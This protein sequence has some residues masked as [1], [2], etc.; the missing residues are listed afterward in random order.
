M[1]R[2]GIPS[3]QQVQLSIRYDNVTIPA[4]YTADIVVQRKVILELKAVEHIGRLQEAQKPTCL[5]LSGC[6][7]GIL[8]NFYTVSLTDGIRR[9]VI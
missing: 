5:R 8:I 4:G 1:A 2:N 6:R 7:I 9:R 3:D